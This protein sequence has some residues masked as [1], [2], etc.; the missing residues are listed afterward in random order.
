MLY[1]AAFY[2]I[3]VLI[4]L[5]VESLMLHSLNAAFAPPL[6]EDHARMVKIVGIAMTCQ[7]HHQQLVKQCHY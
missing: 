6:L 4:N 5:F 7:R 2:E 3:G 1:A